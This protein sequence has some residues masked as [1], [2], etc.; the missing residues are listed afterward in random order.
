M[1]IIIT[2]ATLLLTFLGGIVALRFKDNLHLVLGFSAGAVIA[3]A[4]FDILPEAIELSSDYFPVSTITSITALGFII[5]MII[6]RF[7]L[8]HGHTL[9]HK[10][11]Y[12][13]M[14][15][16][17]GAL[18][19]TMH[20]F[21]DGLAVGLAFQ[22]SSTVGAIVATAVLLHKFSDG[23]NIVNIILVNKGSIKSAYKWLS[24]NSFASVFGIIATFFFSIPDKFLGIL[25]ALF[26]GFFIYIGASEMLPESHHRHPKI[27]TTLMTL[28]G[29]AVLFVAI[30]LA[31]I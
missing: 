7:L 19:M 9:E 6:D 31:E 5:F 22:I 29:V 25:L 15:G 13:T 17:V 18:T 24:L 26:C 11:N 10:D 27:I 21:F 20:S 1:I 3:V 2:I 23:M 4:F 16:P 8:L 28:L 14:R 30:H 12:P